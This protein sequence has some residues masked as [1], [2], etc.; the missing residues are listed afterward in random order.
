MAYLSNYHKK[1]KM[2]REWK[3]GIQSFK[4][5]KSKKIL[6]DASE[7]KINYTKFET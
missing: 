4:R 6:E 7:I 5:D 2:I 1:R 3:A